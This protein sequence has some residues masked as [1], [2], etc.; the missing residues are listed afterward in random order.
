M[1]LDFYLYINKET[2]Q[3]KNGFLYFL[4]TLLPSSQNGHEW[5]HTTWGLAGERV[6]ASEHYFLRTRLQ[7]KQQAMKP[8]HRKITTSIR[9]TARGEVAQI[10]RRATPDASCAA[11]EQEVNGASDCAY[12]SSR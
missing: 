6:A 9:Q 11:E 1:L 4:R 5:V 3:K 10:G 7:I 12:S 8:I 2:K